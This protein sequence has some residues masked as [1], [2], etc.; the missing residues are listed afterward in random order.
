MEI[1]KWT[2]IEKWSIFA[3][4]RLQ[5]W[6]NNINEDHVGNLNKAEGVN[7]KILEII[8]WEKF[9]WEWN[10]DAKKTGAIENKC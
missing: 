10:Q 7:R 6:Q 8:Y 9:R 4:R 5:E 3:D 1:R 2:T